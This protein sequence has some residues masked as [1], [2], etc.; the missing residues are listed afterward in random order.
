MRERV[1][2][3]EVMH[4]EY[5]GVNEG[6]SVRGAADLMRSD[7]VGCAVVLHGNEPVGLLTADDVIKLVA[8]SRDPEETTVADL[9]RQPIVSIDADST[10]REAI[11][12][13]ADRDAKHLV[14]VDTGSVSGVLSE[15]DLLKANTMFLQSNRTDRDVVAT[16]ET[17]TTVTGE[18]ESEEQSNDPYTQGVCEVCGSL[19]AELRDVN[20]QLVCTACRS[21]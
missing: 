12:Q 8:T 20:G 14:V 16:R 19:T 7:G 11:E 17:N 9:M 15:H 3:R 6:D 21:V 18:I 5:V 10:V 4:R 2:V 13:M 1:S